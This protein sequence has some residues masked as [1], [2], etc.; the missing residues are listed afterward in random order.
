MQIILYMIVTI[1]ICK[2]ICIVG[3]YILA[4]VYFEYT[5]NR[6]NN[7]D[8]KLMIEKTIIKGNCSKSKL[9][10]KRLGYF[11][12]GMLLTQ[13][14]Y[15]GQI[16]SHSI[17][18]WI[19]RNVYKMKIASRVVIYGNTELRSP[20]NIK[21]GKGSIIGD[22]AILDARRGIEIGENV[23]FSTGVWIWTEQHDYNCPQFSCTD[24]GGKVIIGDR[25]WLSCRSIVLP[26]VTIGEGAVI[27]AGAVVTQDV[28][29]Y[30]IYGGV[31]AK[32][33]GERN[34]NLEYVFDGSKV[35]FF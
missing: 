31:P 16:P 30:T 27:A 9:L 22:Q 25:A 21:I 13:A 8:E 14:V 4:F 29:P 11:L 1:F 32:K 6:V 23:N 34:R 5:Q 33:I 12:G 3:S 19:Y 18:N 26:G 35:D 2:Y 7:N 20:N 17:R 15:T 28:P 10:K 24:K